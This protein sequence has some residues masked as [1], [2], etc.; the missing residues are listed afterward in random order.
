M[1]SKKSRRLPQWR[2]WS[3][4]L[5]FFNHTLQI[6]LRSQC[7][8]QF[9]MHVKE[10]TILGLMAHTRWFLPYFVEKVCHL[11]DLLL[12]AV[13]KSWVSF[14]PKQTDNNNKTRATTWHTNTHSHALPTW[15]HHR[16]AFVSFR[17]FS[18]KRRGK[19][20]GR[21]KE[22]INN[23]FRWNRKRGEK[24]TRKINIEAIR[25]HWVGKLHTWISHWVPTCLRDYSL[26]D[27]L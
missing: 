24:R 11:E 10:Y 15:R 25:S 4:H 20:G 26:A 6:L 16:F 18:E 8:A 13:Q 17:V 23:I 14:I 19:E 22:Y 2:D 27:R 3:F 1:K 7:P 9:D 21:E 5:D 12:H